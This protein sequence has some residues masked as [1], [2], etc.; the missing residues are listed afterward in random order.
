MSN[1]RFLKTEKAIFVAYCKLQDYPSAKKLARRAQ[2]SRSTLYRHHKIVQNIPQ[3]YENYLINVYHRRIK[4]YHPKSYN[5]LEIIFLRT[6]VFIS[7]NKEIFMVLF[8]EGRK[9]II[10]KMFDCL[11]S[12]ILGQWNDAKISDKIYSI[13]KN[14]VFGIIETWGHHHFSPQRINIALDNIMFLTKTA[15]KRLS[16]LK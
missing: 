2:I 10:P 12:D 8:N 6:L 9:D 14:E 15:P 11:R 5:D 3:D 7:N 4:K 16:G 13:Y 1:K